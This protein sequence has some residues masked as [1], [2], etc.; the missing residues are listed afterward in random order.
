MQNVKKYLIIMV[1][2]AFGIAVI[3]SCIMLFSVKKVSAEF[4]VIGES[5]AT[6]IQED[7]DAAFK[8]KSLVF[9]KKSEVYA[10]CDKYPYYEVISV[11]KEYPNVLKI[12]ITKRLE[13]FKVQTADKTYILDGEGVVLNDTG[14][15]E[16]SSRVI[17]VNLGDVQVVNG[18]VG[19]KIATTDDN[20]F[21]SV[22][23]TSRTLGLTDSVKEIK[24]DSGAA[25]HDAVFNTYTGVEVCVWGVEDQ[26]ETKIKRAFALYEKLSDYQKTAFKIVAYKQDNGDVVASWTSH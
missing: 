6:E 22:L 18:T 9:L 26:G 8:G 19:E 10:I 14:K 16:F 13:T 11:T 3:A 25:W 1:A 24:I 2:V 20:L 5:Q 7:L 12:E 17:P 23:K 21:Y 15:T 4:S